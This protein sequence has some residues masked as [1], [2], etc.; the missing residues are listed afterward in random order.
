MITAEESDK[1]CRFAGV[2]RQILHNV[3][4]DMAP[5]HLKGALK[6]QWSPDNPTRNFCYVVAE[7]LKHFRLAPTAT[8]WSLQ[9][10]GD[11]VKHYFNR[12]A[13]GT[14]I[15]LTGEQF[16]NGEVVDYTKAKKANFMYPSPSKRA[17]ILNELYVKAYAG[18]N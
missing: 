7:W 16:V 9:I 14:L 4:R 11:S 17:R 10:P 2:D 8:A 5:H 15:D 3:L 6:K 13:D 1:M 18:R 12:L